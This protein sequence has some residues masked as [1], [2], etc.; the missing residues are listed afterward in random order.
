LHIEDTYEDNVHGLDVIDKTSSDTTS[1]KVIANNDLKIL[2]DHRT[3][4]DNPHEV[5]TAQ[6][7]A[8]SETDLN[9]HAG[10][11]TIHVPTGAIFAFATDTVPEGYLECDG[12][13]LSTT[14]YSNLY[15]IIGTTF[16]SGSGTFNLPD[17]RGQFI[18]GWDNGR[19]LDP[20]S[21]RTFGSSQAESFKAH[22]H[23]VQTQASNDDHD[24]YRCPTGSS[25]GA[26]P[27]DSP[28]HFEGA[29]TTGGD[30][31]RPTNIALMY[32]IKY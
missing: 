7:S 14:T 6:I 24:S 27:F 20:T 28:S 26:T 18:R 15:N 5:T 25:Y 17:L 32:C 22:T 12:S 2:E 11:Q 13:T 19:G 16:G 4:T 9:D 10:D 30:E 21:P 1:N 23:P 31:T 29:R 8:A 3:D